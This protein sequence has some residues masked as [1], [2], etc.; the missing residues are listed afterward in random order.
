M[1]LRHCVYGLV[2]LAEAV[3]LAGCIG[4]VMTPIRGQA[5]AAPTA[6]QSLTLPTVPAATE[7][8]TPTAAIAPSETPAPAASPPG[9]STLL[10]QELPP[11]YP[12]PVASET[13][14]VGEGQGATT[15]I[16]DLAKK[17]L[18]QRLSVA[19]DQITVVSSEYMDWPDS[20]LG[21]P[22]PGMAYSQ[23]ITPGYRIILLYGQKQYD[24]HT[25]LKGTLVLCAK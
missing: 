18:A 20:S 2:A 17:D 8:A 7:L 1:K 4:I 16:I 22:E 23:V 15:A 21:C 5:P 11:A 9:M 19:G 3:A 12:M 6:T 13:A 14:P 24:Y 10:P 25:G